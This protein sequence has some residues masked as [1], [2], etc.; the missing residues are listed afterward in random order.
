VL[1]DFFD[2]PF[3]AAAVVGVTPF[4]AAAFA[5]VAVVAPAVILLSPLPIVVGSDRIRGVVT[6]L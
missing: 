2:V 3:I 6:M 1:S 5:G 4:V